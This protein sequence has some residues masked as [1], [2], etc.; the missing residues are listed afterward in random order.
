MEG[1]LS[2]TQKGMKKP[3]HFCSGSCSPRQTRTAD[4]VVNSHLLY[5]LSYRGMN[6]LTVLI[7]GY[8]VNPFM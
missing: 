2:V 7:H 8:L 3:E 6:I 1:S 5:R 4:R